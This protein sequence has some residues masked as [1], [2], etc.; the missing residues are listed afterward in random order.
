MTITNKNSGFIFPV[1]RVRS[2]LRK[3]T[4]SNRRI[5][6][7]CPLYLTSALENVAIQV[8][9]LAVR[10]IHNNVA[11]SGKRKTIKPRN[12]FLGVKLCNDL[13][14]M[15]ADSHFNMVGVVPNIDTRLLRKKSKN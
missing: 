5:Y 2:N 12:I 7:K 10:S 3:R 8:L 14:N 4:P 13:D 1:S 9:S 11:G 6:T 15:F